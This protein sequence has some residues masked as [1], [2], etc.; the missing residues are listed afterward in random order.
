MANKLGL[1]ELS[2]PI[3]IEAQNPN[4]VDFMLELGPVDISVLQDKVATVDQNLWKDSNTDMINPNK[5][6]GPLSKTK[7]ITFKFSNKHIEPVIYYISPLWYEWKSILLPIMDQATAPYEYEHK[8]YTRAMLAY[9]PAGAN[10]K[11]HSDGQI[12][13]SRP[14]KIHIPLQTNKKTFFSHGNGKRYFFEVGHAYEV[15]NRRQHAVMNNGET[16]RIHF[17]FECVKIDAELAALH[18]H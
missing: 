14:H 3:N 18:D 8:Y 5:R 7:H 15:N 12:K 16:D 1:E 17:I 10:I 6:N 11:P 2:F 9:L 4:K 13:G